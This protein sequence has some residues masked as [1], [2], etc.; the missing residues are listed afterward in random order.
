MHRVL[1]IRFKINLETSE[2]ILGRL[3]LDANLDAII[4]LPIYLQGVT[5]RHEI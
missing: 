1:W 2:K 4:C 3:Q 5:V